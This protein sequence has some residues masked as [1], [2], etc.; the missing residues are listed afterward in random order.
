MAGAGKISLSRLRLSSHYSVLARFQAAV[1]EA[2]SNLRLE[3]PDAAGCEEVVQICRHLDLECEVL[4]AAA[5]DGPL[6]HVNVRR[7]AEFF[8]DD[9]IQ[10]TA[11]GGGNEGPLPLAACVA[12]VPQTGPAPAPGATARPQKKRAKIAEEAERL[13]TNQSAVGK[14]G[15]PPRLAE[16]YHALVDAF[17]G[18]HAQ[19]AKLLIDKWQLSGLACPSASDRSSSSS[20]SKKKRKKREKKEKKKEKKKDK[21][22]RKQERL[23]EEEAKTQGP[24]LK[25]ISQCLAESSTEDS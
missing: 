3:L 7:S 16:F 13:L 5:C 4:P 21:K 15:A 17:P 20:S 23:Q 6:R 14:R 25:Q 8:E 12:E 2:T 11:P 18:F 1:D 24:S 19:L 10:G 22:K 9:V